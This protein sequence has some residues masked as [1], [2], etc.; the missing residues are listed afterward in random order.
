MDDKLQVYALNH[1][2]R[3]QDGRH[4][5]FSVRV[6]EVIGC[7]SFEIAITD[8]FEQLLIK[9]SDAFQIGGQQK[10]QAEGLGC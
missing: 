2:N 4:L 1:V 10:Q 6:D 7:L 8:V 5:A 3:S 9:S